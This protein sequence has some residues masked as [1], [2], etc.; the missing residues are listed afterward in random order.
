MA[1]EIHERLQIYQLKVT[2]KE[3]KPLIWRRIL[4]NGD[5]N[6]YKLHKVLQAILGWKNYHLHTLTFEDIVYAIPSPEDCGGR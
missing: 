6:L 3:I 1:R 4:V 5:I 2:M